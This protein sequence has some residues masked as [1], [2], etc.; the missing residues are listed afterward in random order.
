MKEKKIL[1]K[2]YLKNEPGQAWRYRPIISTSRELE[3]E[4][5]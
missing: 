3:I 5:S 2:F 4:G 1:A